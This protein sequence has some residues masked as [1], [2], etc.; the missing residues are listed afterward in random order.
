[1]TSTPRPVFTV[2]LSTLALACAGDDP[3]SKWE[4]AVDTLASGAVRVVHTPPPEGPEP[5]W[6]IEEELRVGT[7]IEGGP[8]SFGQIKGLAVTRGGHA[9]VLDAQARQLR[10]F[11]T[12]GNHV[13][14]FGRQGGGPGEFEEPFGLMR[15]PDD[16]LWVPDVPT[17]RMSVFH[18]DSGFVE[19]FPLRFLRYGFVWD[20]AMLDDGRIIKPS[21]VLETRRDVLRT[22]DE[23]MTQVDSVLL[24]EAPS[25]EPGDSPSSF[26][27]EAPG[28]MPRGYISVPFY[29]RGESVFDRAGGIWLVP[30]GDPS[31]RIT[32]AS[33]EGDSLV[34]IETR[35]P[36]VP[37]PESVRDSAIDRIRALLRDRGGDT[38]RDW[39]KVPSVRPA[40][41]GLF[42][43]DDGRLWARVASPDTVVTFDVYERD[44]RYAGTAVTS[45]DPYAYVDPVVRD[46]KF[47]AIVTDE[48]DVQYLVRARLRE[49]SEAAR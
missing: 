44:G 16:R 36:P 35:R 26:Y 37:I 45:L 9:V 5:R 3:H 23:T 1:M 43:A 33:L 18:A 4:Q 24:P 42:V 32:H 21:I 19:S 38:D 8:T 22:Y 27:W 13:A 6:V 7:V 47:W 40:V 41:T 25:V 29:P 11:D 2:V 17:N 30:G 39:S 12:D 10:V 34:A 20:G 28:G 14:S 31:Y 46:G 15:S 49:Q 48:F